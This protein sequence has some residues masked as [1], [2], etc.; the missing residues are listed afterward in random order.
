ME[1]VEQNDDGNVGLRL[2]CQ[3]TI[4]LQNARQMCDS[5]ISINR[6]SIVLQYLM[7]DRFENQFFIHLLIL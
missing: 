5:M 6:Q 2:Y 7:N 4:I 3:T 1:D